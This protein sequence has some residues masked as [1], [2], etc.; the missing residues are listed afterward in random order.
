MFSVRVEYVIRIVAIEFPALKFMQ[1]FMRQLNVR[2][3]FYCLD[4]K[5]HK[6]NTALC[7]IR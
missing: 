4:I 6:Q 1:E 2:K 7:F 5:I 3:D